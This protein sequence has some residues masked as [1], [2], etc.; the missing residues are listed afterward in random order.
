MERGKRGD[1]SS[2]EAGPEDREKTGEADAAGGDG[3]RR[4]E[5]DLPHVEKTEPVAGAVGAVD[6]AEKGVAAAGAREG[7]AELGPDEAV[8]DGDGCAEHPGPDGEA[9]ARGGDDERKGDEGADADHLEH[10]EEDGGAEAD[11]ALARD[12]RGVRSLTG[13]RDHRAAGNQLITRGR[14][15]RQGIDECECGFEETGWQ[16]FVHV[17]N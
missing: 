4:G 5:A 3:E 6:L 14:E 13:G 15:G 12:S 9:I 8:G 7:R 11:A 1:G 10:V 17:C 2:V 16:Q